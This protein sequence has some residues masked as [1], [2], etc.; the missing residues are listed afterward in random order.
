MALFS[1]L[2]GALAAEPERKL[3]MV[4]DFVILDWRLPMPRSV[5]PT[6]SGRPTRLHTA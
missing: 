1:G 6:R 4:S 3:R 2:L 5:W